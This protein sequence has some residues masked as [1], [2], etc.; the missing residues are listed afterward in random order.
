MS[1]GTPHSI[2]HPIYQA[3]ATYLVR[4]EVD[5]RVLPPISFRQCKDD[6][7]ERNESLLSDSRVQLICLQ[8]YKR[9]SAFSLF[10]PLL[11]GV[12]GK[13]R[14]KIGGNREKNREKTEE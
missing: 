13:N 14:E 9:K 5:F 4:C 12:S 10:S 2:Y 8:K 1:I 7:N 3:F 6:A 11:G